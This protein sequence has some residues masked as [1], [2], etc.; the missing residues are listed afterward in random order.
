M[1]FTTL[2]LASKR[3][4]NRLVTNGASTYVHYFS[5]D[6]GDFS[7]FYMSIKPNKKYVIVF[8]V[9]ISTYSRRKLY[10]GSDIANPRIEGQLSWW[11]QYF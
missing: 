2:S 8:L 10:Y 1:L 11:S 7:V 4:I 9:L 3:D 5:N 6:I